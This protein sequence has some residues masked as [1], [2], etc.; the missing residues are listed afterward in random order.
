MWQLLCK[1]FITCKY[2]RH[3]ETAVS[4]MNIELLKC[5]LTVQLTKISITLIRYWNTQSIKCENVKGSFIPVRGCTDQ[6]F[7]MQ[8][9]IR[10]VQVRTWK[11]MLLLLSMKIHMIRWT[12]VICWCV[13]DETD[14]TKHSGT[15]KSIYENCK[16]SVAVNI[17]LSDWLQI[18]QEAKQGCVPWFFNLFTDN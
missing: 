15:M 14:I 1:L 4:D 16:T 6:M 2:N 5:S 9:L 12:G 13:L 10:G 17:I 3:A 8:Y 7:S 11:Y 18:R